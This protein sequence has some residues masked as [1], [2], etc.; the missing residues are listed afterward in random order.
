MR[1][2]TDETYLASAT[3]VIK[4]VDE[5]AGIPRSAR[6]LDVGCAAGRLAMPL[7]GYLDPS[8]GASY[9]GF[10]VKADRIEWAQRHVGASHPHFRFAHIDVLNATLNPSGS[11]LGESLRFPYPDEAFDL[12]LLHSVFTHLLPD[13]AWHYLAE[14]RRCLAP[15]GRIYATWYLWDEATANSVS[16]SEVL[17]DFPIARAAHRIMDASRPEL[18]VAYDYVRLRE[19]LARNGL[20]IAVEQRGTWRSRPTQDQDCLILVAS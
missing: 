8:A 3:H 1:N 15:G 5:L 16:T 4:R 18:A 6:V 11:V 2:H 13:D 19:E 14:L 7:L 17:W 20:R 12:A 10:D 9:D